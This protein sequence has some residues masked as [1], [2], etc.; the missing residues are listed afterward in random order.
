MVK[1]LDDSY[2][3]KISELWRESFGDDSK[4]VDYYLQNIFSNGNAIGKIFDNR[5]VSMM[6]LINSFL[7]INGDDFTCRYIYAA[8]TAKDCRSHGYMGELINYAKEFA[9]NESISYLALVPASESLFEFYSKFGF[10]RFFY[11]K[12]NNNI[13]DYNIK[14]YNHLHFEDIEAFAA[15]VTDSD[16]QRKSYPMDMDIE[17]N[18]ECN[19]MVLPI[20]EQAEYLIENKKAFF[21]KTMS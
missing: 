11:R 5:L 1:F 4:T 3:I 16:Y 19:G 13:F 21:C 20:N 10:K 17:G 12:I 7:N 6:F 9:T 14:N 18:I 15:K 8:C 2:K